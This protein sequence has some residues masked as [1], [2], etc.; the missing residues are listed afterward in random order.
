[1]RLTV[2]SRI[3][4]KEVSEIFCSPD[5]FEVLFSICR[6]NYFFFCGAANRNF[7]AGAFLVFVGSDFCLLCVCFGVDLGG[8]ALRVLFNVDARDS[9]GSS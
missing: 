8:S 4:S 6:V 9:P 1:M 3:F 5:V 2:S 7:L